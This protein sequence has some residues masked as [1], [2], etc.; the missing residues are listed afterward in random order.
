M[1]AS[2]TSGQSSNPVDIQPAELRRNRVT[3]PL[4]R[5]AMEPGHLLNS[6]LTCQSSANAR[7][8]KWRQPYVP[9]VQQL[10]SSSD[11]NNNTN[12]AVGGSS[13]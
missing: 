10:I 9:A 12:G 4:A 3:L 13:M 5:H 6:V 8:L 7:R 11:N 2:Y 1:P